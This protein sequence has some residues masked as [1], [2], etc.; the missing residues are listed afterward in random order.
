MLNVTI[1]LATEEECCL[2]VGCSERAR[3]VVSAETAK[4][5]TKWIMCSLKHM[6]KVMEGAAMLYRAQN[7]LRNIEVD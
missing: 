4:W 6:D 7:H 5:S 3:W 1:D 2:F